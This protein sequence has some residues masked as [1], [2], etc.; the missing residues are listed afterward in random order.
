MVAGFFVVNSLRIRYILF[1][2]SILKEAEYGSF[3]FIQDIFS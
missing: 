2:E 1:D 3:K